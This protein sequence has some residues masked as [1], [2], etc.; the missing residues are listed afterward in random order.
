MKV[1]IKKWMDILQSYGAIF[2]NIK[3]IE[4]NGNF[5][6]HAAD[7][8]K[9]SILK[10]V[11]SVL[12]PADMIEIDDN[13]HRISDSFDIEPDLREVFDSYLELIFSDKHMRQQL[14]INESFSRI[15]NNLKSKLLNFGLVNL[16]SKR[17]RRQLK[18]ALASARTI[19]IDGKIW[20][21]PIVGFMNHDF[22]DGITFDIRQGSVTIKGKA[23]STG[24]LFA[25]YNGVADAFSM[26]NTFSFVSDNILAF[27]M[28]IVISLDSSRKL[29]IGRELL[30]Y[31][32]TDD[33]LFL[34]QYSI[35]ENTIKLSHL[36]LGS[37]QVPDRPYKSFKKLWEERLH[38]TDTQRVYS[39]IKSLNITTLVSILRMCDK[40]EDNSAVEM[41]KEATWQQLR[42][43]GGSYES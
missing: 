39:I 33:G 16:F 21:M 4:K 37:H 9:V 17:N 24:E 20:L 40:A 28:D 1:N 10:V 5:S 15:P 19:L 18:V 29:I 26:L 25:I 27:S 8:E 36:W 38:Q 41:L 31:E 42:L 14:E 30:K 2:E 22:K 6:V 12:I 43:I 13:T 23:S 7:K 35:S 3:L 34:P 32:K 11:P